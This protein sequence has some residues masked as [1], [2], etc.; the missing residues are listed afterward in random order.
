MNNLFVYGCSFT[1]GNGCLPVNE[2]Y[3]QYYKNEDDL[4]WP[5]IIAKKLGFKL[6]NYGMGAYSND[7][8]LDSMINS[9][10][11]IDSGDIVIIQKTFT[12]RIDIGYRRDKLEPY[13][14]RD[15]SFLTITP[16]STEALLNQGYTKKEVE[17]IL[18]TMWCIDGE[19]NDLRINN[20]FDF[21]QKLFKYRGVKRTV[22]WDVL[23][24]YT[25]Y[26][27]IQM[28]TDGVIKDAH[29]SFNGH[30]DFSDTMY[31]ILTKII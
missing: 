15:K 19:S 17:A 27:T 9:F 22:Q 30:R 1:H 10:D 24:Y 26:E 23:D 18:Y 13:M 5:E 12:H 25:K 28:Q 8:I 29:W 7:K 6:Y 31:K 2:Y 4:I 3:T 16:A 21:F 11:M 14:N 20:R